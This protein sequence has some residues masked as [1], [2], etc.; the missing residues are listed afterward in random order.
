MSSCK[1]ELNVLSTRKTLKYPKKNVQ[2]L[3]M[4]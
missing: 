1:Y 3:V 2:S 4:S